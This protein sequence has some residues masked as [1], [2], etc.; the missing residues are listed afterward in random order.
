MLAEPR[1]LVVED[2]F[3]IAFDLS[4]EIEVAGGRV[5]GPYATAEEALRALKAESVDGAILDAEIGD[6]VT[7]VAFALL[8]RNLPIVIH[9]RAG[10]GL[11]AG[12][13]EAKVRLPIVIKPAAAAAVAALVDRLRQADP[14]VPVLAESK[15]GKSSQPANHASAT[16]DPAEPGRAEGLPASELAQARR[17]AG[18]ALTRARMAAPDWRQ[19]KLWQQLAEEWST[20]A[21]ALERD[22][23][24]GKAGAPSNDSGDRYKPVR[25]RSKR[26]SRRRGH[27]LTDE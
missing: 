18:H 8:K 13:R 26:F 19:M 22:L 11:P 10:A 24:E 16:P 23:S 12:L 20:R 4:K 25:N 6:K 5:V 9:T 27:L 2:D 15:P 21:A 17:L 1:V 3:V 7:P 14:G